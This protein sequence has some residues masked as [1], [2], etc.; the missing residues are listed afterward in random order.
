MPR[1]LLGQRGH[2][3]RGHAMS[4]IVFLLCAIALVVAPGTSHAQCTTSSPCTGAPI[5]IGTFGGTVSNASGVNSDGSIVVGF[6]RFA[7]DSITHAFRWTSAGG[8]QDLGTLGGTNSAAFGVN[9]DGSVVVGSSYLTAGGLIHAF[10]WTSL[11]GMVSRSAALH[12]KSAG[13][14]RA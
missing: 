4:I 3:A 13:N 10:R 6:A 12:R 2:A 11:G 8:M 9:G 7:G 5:D 14:S 1:M